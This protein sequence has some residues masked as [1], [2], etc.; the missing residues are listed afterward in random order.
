MPHKPVPLS[1]YLEI[2]GESLA[3]FAQRCTDHHPKGQRVHAQTILNV[4][5][6]G[7]CRF[8]T[9]VAILEAA[10]AAP[11]PDGEVVTGETLSAEAPA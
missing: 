2:K 8:D 10:K 9:G 1:K 5:D 6:G 7:G 4:R 11:G 3:G